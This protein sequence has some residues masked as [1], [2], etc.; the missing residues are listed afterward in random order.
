MFFT[1]LAVV[2][3]L[4]VTVYILYFVTWAVFSSFK[5]TDELQITGLPILKTKIWNLTLKCGDA[6]RINWIL[7]LLLF[8]GS[9][10]ASLPYNIASNIIE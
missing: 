5:V 4:K 7:L 8:I 3:A 9:E 10:S 2:L 1:V 6:R